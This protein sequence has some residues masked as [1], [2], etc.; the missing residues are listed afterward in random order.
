VSAETLEKA[1]LAAINASDKGKARARK[2][3]Q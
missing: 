2:Y 1:V 3:F